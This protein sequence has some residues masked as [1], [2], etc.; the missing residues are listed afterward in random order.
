MKIGE[1]KDEKQTIKEKLTKGL[2]T[3]K[4]QSNYGLWSENPISNR[5]KMTAATLIGKRAD[6]YGYDDFQKPYSQYFVKKQEKESNQILPAS[7]LKRAKGP[8][9]QIYLNSNYG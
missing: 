1:K 5:S 9:E 6:P 2:Y 7:Y 3:T 4:N 8:L